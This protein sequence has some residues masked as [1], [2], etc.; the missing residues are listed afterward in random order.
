MSYQALYRV[1]RP[2]T[3]AALIGQ[4]AISKTLLNA[5][6]FNRLAHAYLFCGP[7]GTGKTSTSK[8]LAKAVNCLD[9]QN[10]EPCNHCENCRAINEDRFLDVI[11]IDAASNR[12]ID[13]IRTIREQVRFTPS[14]GKRKVYIIDEVHMLTTEAFNALLKT[15]EEPPEHVLFILATTDP[16]KVP[17]TVLSRT[18]RFD[19]HRIPTPVLM[20]HLQEIA[21]EES[22]SIADDA[23]A[24]IAKSAAGGMR[25]AISLLDQTIAFGGNDIDK[26]TVLQII[27][28]LDDTTLRRLVDCLISGDTAGLFA[29]VEEA[30][31]Q[32]SDA[33]SLVHALLNHLR[34]LLM[35]QVGHGS[36]PSEAKLQQAKALSLRQLEQLLKKAADAE[37]DLRIAPDGELVLECT[38][39]EM[40]LLLHDQAPAAAPAPHSAHLPRAGSVHTAPAAPAATPVATND[41]AAPATPTAA[42]VASHSGNDS[43]NLD[44]IKDVWPQVLESIKDISIRIHAFVRPA[45][46]ESYQDDTLTLR[47]PKSAIFN[48]KQMKLNDNKTVLTDT[49]GKY[50]P[51]PVKIDCLLEEDDVKEPSIDLIEGIHQVFGADVPVEIIDTPTKKY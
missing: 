36:E 38:L 33:R 12:G 11:E 21:E 26:A 30:L 44:A 49:L 34:D 23:L 8:I 1:Y 24:I 15:L 35:L 25:D 10:G 18:Q 50:Y 46:L 7:R 3:F 14:M 13:E 6:R 40:A 39:V 4:D 16:Q 43:A 47:F 45:E 37:R 41:T 51:H 20:Q 31:C 48:C 29:I 27:G 42:P 19:F 22:I 28:G 9:P 2:Q 32:G 17:K 5:L